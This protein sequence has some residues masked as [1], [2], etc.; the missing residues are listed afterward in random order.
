[1][2][3]NEPHVSSIVGYLDG[4]HAPGHTDLHE[5]LSSS[6]H[7]LL[8]HGLAVPILRACNARSLVGIA[9]DYRPQTPASP[10]MHDR[11]AA[12]HEGGVINR[13]FLDPLVGR[14]YPEDM[15]AA[16][17]DQMTFVLAGD[18]EKIARPSTSWDST[19]TSAISRALPDVPKSRTCPERLAQ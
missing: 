16:Y 19:T 14:G 5:A 11:Q 9:L 3:L 6:H 2:T 18:L 12:W 8:A 13:W 4:R 1:M 17:G 10:S 15:R 7:L